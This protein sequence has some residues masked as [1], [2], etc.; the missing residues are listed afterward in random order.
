M[1]QLDIFLDYK[2]KEKT[3]GVRFDK[4]GNKVK[5][6]GP[7]FESPYMTIPE[8]EKAKEKLLNSPEP[9]DILKRLKNYYLDIL[10]RQQEQLL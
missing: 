8:I 9:Q 4:K 1:E 5:V 3:D 2:I 6:I 10:K 7:F